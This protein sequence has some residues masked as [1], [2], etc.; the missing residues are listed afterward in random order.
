MEPPREADLDGAWSIQD[1]AHD[2]EETNQHSNSH[3]RLLSHE[4]TPRDQ[5]QPYNYTANYR[6]LYFE[7]D[8]RAEIDEGNS[9]IE[10]L[11]LSQLTVGSH[12]SKDFK[13]GEYILPPHTED[14]HVDD[15]EVN[16]EVSDDEVMP[17]F[18]AYSSTMNSANA[19]NLQTSS[20]FQNY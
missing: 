4:H 2:Y 11:E 1:A 12:A 9:L 8:E 13:N 19:V 20:G 14:H 3:L 15:G 10:D 5:V 6:N 18:C 7:D 17:Q 16:L